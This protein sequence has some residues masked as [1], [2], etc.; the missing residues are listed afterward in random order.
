MRAR[1]RIGALVVALVALL[2]ACTSSTGEPPGP[3]PSTIDGSPAAAVTVKIAFVEDLAPEEAA[4]RVAPA[5]Q[6]ARLAIDTATLRGGLPAEIELVAMDTGGDPASVAAEIAEDPAFVGVIGAPFLTGQAALGAVLDAAGVPTITLSTLGPDLSTNGWT[7]WRRAVAGQVDQAR[8][9][10]R[11][12]EGLHGAA[13]GVCL[14]GDGS[15]VSVGLLNAVS[16]TIRAPVVL[17]SRLPVAEDG[18]EQAAARVE[19][20][21]CGVV[22]WGGYAGRGALL[23]HQLVEVGL[24]DVP[25]VGGEG[26]KDERFPAVSGSAG[27]GTVASCSCVDLTTSTRFAA[28]R[29]IQD[30]QSDFG[31]P[32]GPYAVEAWDVARMFLQATAA[33]AITRERMA[34][35]LAAMGP[36]Q[37]LAGRYAF[38]P[39]GELTRGSVAVHLFRDE[40]GR[41]LPLER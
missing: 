15:P 30:Y 17:R 38:R 10:A 19:T 29:F 22:V 39:D 26:L 9:I 34:A 32:P 23:R 16:R 18:P 20:S 12:V 25:F 35:A 40:G 27:I 3:A 37:G 31:L 6:G 4:D 8:A 2:A 5:Y 33:G 21:R 11:Y 14:L 13:A 7:T 36:F 41:W 28:Q 24:R 1:S